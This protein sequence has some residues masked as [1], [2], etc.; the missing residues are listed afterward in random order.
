[1][2]VTQ[3]SETPHCPPVRGRGRRH[4]LMSRREDDH[5]SDGGVPSSSRVGRCKTAQRGMSGL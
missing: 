4:C 1:M 2:W 5:G 3:A